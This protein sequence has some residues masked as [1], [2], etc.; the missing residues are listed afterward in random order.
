MC[1]WHN[2]TESTW[3]WELTICLHALGYHLKAHH[4]EVVLDLPLPLH[5]LP[6]V[7]QDEGEVVVQ[8]ELQRAGRGHRTNRVIGHMTKEATAPAGRA[9]NKRIWR[10][11]TYLV[12]LVIREK[13]TLKQWQFSIIGF[14]HITL[15]RLLYLVVLCETQP[16]AVLK[17]N[18]FHQVFL[19]VLL[20]PCF[21]VW[22][23]LQTSRY[24]QVICN[25]GHTETG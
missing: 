22:V 17:L 6:V 19:L 13:K 2:T 7:V 16:V 12:A 18:I 8:V 9:N 4:S 5:L 3:F 25:P 15:Q 14:A 20:A 21:S 11:L 23:V 1:I 24:W 10:S